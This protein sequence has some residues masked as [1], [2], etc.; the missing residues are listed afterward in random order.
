[1]E[2]PSQRSGISAILGAALVAVGGIILVGQFLRIDLWHF[3]WPLF[4]IVPGIALFAWMGSG[5][6]QTAWLAVPASVVTMT[7]LILL[8]QSVTDHWRSWAY[9]WSLI[10]PLAVGIGLVLQGDRV[11]KASLRRTGQRMIRAGLTIFLLTGIFFELVIRTSGS[12]ASQVFWPVMLVI[13][14]LY[15]IVRR[16]PAP[17]PMKET[18]AAA[19]AATPPEVPAVPGPGETE[20]QS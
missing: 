6:R 3:A 13:V 14:G 10:V 20:S 1:M 4:V 8:Y 7:G 18:A 11:G 2:S 12:A 19:L 9:A 16:P 5:G 15:L 17:A